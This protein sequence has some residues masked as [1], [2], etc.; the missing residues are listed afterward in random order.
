VSSIALRLRMVVA[1]LGVVVVG[2]GLLGVISAVSIVCVSIVV[3]STVL[4]ESQQTLSLGGGIGIL[5]FVMASVV[6]LQRA[7]SFVAREFDARDPAPEERARIAPRVRRLAQ[8]YDI[9]EPAIQIA[10]TEALHAS[11]SGLSRRRSTLVISTSTLSALTDAELEGVLAHELAHVV[12]RDAFVCTVVSIPSMIAHT[13]MTWR[14][15]FE[16]DEEHRPTTYTLYDIVGAFF[17]VLGQPFVSVFARQR[18]YAADRA[19]AAV[20]GDSSAV[21]SALQTLSDEAA[22]VPSADLRTVVATA[23]FSIVRP[24]DATINPKYWTGGT[25]PLSYRLENRIRSAIF[26]LHPPIPS[27]VERLSQLT[28]ADS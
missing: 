23:A 17:W 8:Q 19:A 3:N 10:D 12:N 9:P 16:S 28:V 25:P 6:E 20:T 7:D 1:L 14:P 27:R 4:P 2:L 18:E 13:L 22:D 11:V 24:S 5:L 26:D 15:D 21:A